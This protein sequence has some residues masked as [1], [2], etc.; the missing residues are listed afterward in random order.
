[1]TMPLSGGSPVALASAQPFPSAL[2]VDEASVYWFNST[3]GTLVKVPKTG[4]AVV[5]LASGGETNVGGGIALTAT[6]VYWTTGN[7][8]M[9]VTPK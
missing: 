2:A 5:T 9:M 3:D 7:A 1:M 8:V 6:S 4:G